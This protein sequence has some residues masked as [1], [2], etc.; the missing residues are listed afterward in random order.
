[1]PTCFV[2]LHFEFCPGQLQRGDAN[3]LADHTNHDGQC[4]TVPM[5][6][7]AVSL[8]PLKYGHA[9]RVEGRVCIILILSPDELVAGQVFN[10]SVTCSYVY[11]GMG[12]IQLDT[13]GNLEY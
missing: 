8:N 12:K 4:Y 6:S 11:V 10:S 3:D 1:M 13:F 9:S 7:S 5:R 2:K